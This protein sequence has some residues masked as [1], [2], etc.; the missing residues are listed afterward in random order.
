[1]Q[2]VVERPS[3]LDELKR[4]KDKDLIKVVTGIR[5]CGKSTLFELFIS[6]LKDTG[7][8]DEQIIHINLEDADYNF[9]DYKE[10][11]DYI[12]EKVDKEKQYYVFLDEVQNV[13]KFQ[14]AVDSLY[15]KKN[16]DVY[17]TGSNAYLLS[18]ELATLLS[19]RYIEIKMLPLSFKEYASAFNNNNYQKLFL[20][21]MK[22]GGMP[23]NLSILQ[24]NPNDIDKYLDGIFS[25]IVYKDIMARNNITDKM[26]LESVLKFIFDSIGSPISTKKI[27]D[28]LTSKG[29]TTSNHT[30]ENYITAYLESFLIYKAER[31]DVKGKNLLARDYK[32]YVV[33]TG[34]RSYLLGKK[35]N[36]DMGHILENIVYLELLRRGYKVYVGKVD[37]LEVDFVTEN[38]DGLKY[39]Q[40][41]L[42]TRDEKVLE[43]ELRSLRK[44]GDHYP[45]YLLTLDM[46]LETDYDGITKIN[47]IDWL[48]EVE[49]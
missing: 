22:N 43:R 19:G 28:T 48:L 17:I 31:F 7:I 16:I 47:V 2:S 32:Y 21:Y 26:L 18:G 9:K 44:T 35:A 20:D 8:K 37:E 42:T 36:S 45:K 4:W 40:V 5:R 13:S 11:Y 41:A 46:D 15:I 1:M 49:K 14:K 39:Y 12:I 27:S 10:L 3:Y 38:R 30:V 33:D 29:I 25:T 34:L 6:Y 23:G 24:T